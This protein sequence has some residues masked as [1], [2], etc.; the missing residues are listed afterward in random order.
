MNNT[1]VTKNSRISKLPKML[2]PFAVFLRDKLLKSL[3]KRMPQKPN[4]YRYHFDGVATNN[5]V[6]FMEE[7]E[8]LTA[9]NEFKKAYSWDPGLPWRV[10]QFQ[11]AVRQTQKVSGDWVEVGVGRG[12]LMSSAL[13]T[14]PDWNSSERTLH[15]FD[16]FLPWKL[17]DR[18]ENDPNLGSYNYYAKDAEETKSTF[19]KYDRICFHIGNVFSTIPA[20]DIKSI[21]FLS[22]D[23]NHAAAEEHALTNLFPLL[24][25]GAVVILDDYAAARRNAQRITMDK[26]A[27]KLG[28]SILRTPSGQGIFLK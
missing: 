17:N 9:Y 14:Y 16:T 11:W 6:D 27:S 19:D 18:G 20:I 28:F 15:L 2:Q 8:F 22:I 3:I 25:P 7:P 24:S 10:H 4:Q 12:G 26:L 1:K 13:A 23:L 21:A 5:N